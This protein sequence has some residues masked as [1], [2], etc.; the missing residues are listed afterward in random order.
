MPRDA[1]TVSAVPSGGSG[2]ANP[3]GTAINPANGANIPG[4]G[5]SGKLLIR[6]TNTNASN[7]TVTVKA[8]NNPPALRSGL[9]DLTIT[10]PATTGDTLIVVESARFMQADGSINV[11]FGASMTG[12]ISAVRL[13]KGA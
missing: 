10:V 5:D 1:V 8:G 12:I 11:D 6:V 7:R 9:G 13:P 2:L 4:A 3:A